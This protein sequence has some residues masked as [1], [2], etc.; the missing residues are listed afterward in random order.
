MIALGEAVFALHASDLEHL[1]AEPHDQNAGDVGVGGIAPLR[2]LQ[3]L[4]AL[5]LVGH[6][7]AGAMHQSDYAVDVRVLVEDAG[8]LDLFRHEPRHGGRAVHAGEDREVVARPGPPAGAPEALER[9]LLVERQDRLEFCAFRELVVPLEILP[10][11]EVLLMHPF[12]GRD[13]ARR[14]PD[15]LA[16]LQHRR[17]GGDADR[18][19]L[20]PLGHAL[21]RLQPRAGRLAGFEDID[22]HDDI[23]LR[24]QADRAGR[25]RYGDG[26]GIGL[27][28]LADG[29]GP[30]RA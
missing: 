16:E 13:V 21:P 29:D 8:P 11:G 2:A 1:A 26:H 19:H 15:D 14:K 10:H 23:V 18:R 12:A 28:F 4:E 25:R 9:R 6:A 3:R 22:G 7:A 30:R 24:L 20:V 5:A 17:A 27:G